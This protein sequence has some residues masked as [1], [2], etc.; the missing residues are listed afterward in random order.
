MITIKPLTTQENQVF[1]PPLRFTAVLEKLPATA[2]HP[3]I[4]ED[5]LASHCHISSLFAE[6]L[7]FVLYQTIFATDIV[8]VNQINQ[9]IIAEI[10]SFHISEK[11][12]ISVYVFHKGNVIFGKPFG[13]SFTI[14]HQKFS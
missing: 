1:A 5:I 13:I 8:S 4:L 6:T 12:N 2:Y 9:I 14:A 7:F 11:F 10:Q 3:K